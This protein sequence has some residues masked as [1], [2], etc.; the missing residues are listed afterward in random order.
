MLFNVLLAGAV[1]SGNKTVISDQFMARI[2]MRKDILKL[3]GSMNATV[4]AK[5]AEQ[6]LLR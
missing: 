2:R 5:T 4:G 1:T 6:G 3:I